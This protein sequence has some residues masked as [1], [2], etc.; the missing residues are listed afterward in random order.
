M[1]RDTRQVRLHRANHAALDRLLSN[2]HL[3]LG[4]VHLTNVWMTTDADGHLSS[5]SFLRPRAGVFSVSPLSLFAASLSALRL[6]RLWTRTWRLE[7]VNS[8]SQGHPPVGQQ[9]SLL[10][11]LLP[12]L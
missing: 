5:A 8:L 11:R 7:N 4:C 12:E 9:I 2:Q 10:A 3:P 1:E 6:H